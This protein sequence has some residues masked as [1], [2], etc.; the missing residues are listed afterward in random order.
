MSRSLIDKDNSSS[1]SP[2]SKPSSS[3]CVIILD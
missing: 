3:P 2:K 1:T